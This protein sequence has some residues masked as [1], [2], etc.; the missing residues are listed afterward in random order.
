MSMTFYLIIIPSYFIILPFCL[1]II[2]FQLIIMTFISEFTFYFYNL[3][4]SFITLTSISWLWLF[5]LIILIQLWLNH[6]FFFFLNQVFHNIYFLFLFCLAE[7]SFH[8]D[9]CPCLKL[10]LNRVINYPW[11]KLQNDEMENYINTS[12]VLGLR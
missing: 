3:L 1:I 4:L 6:V 10:K 5:N 12:Y 7:I 11:C 8:I 2:L 9:L